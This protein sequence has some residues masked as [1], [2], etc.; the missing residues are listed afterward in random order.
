MATE[1]SQAPAALPQLQSVQKAMAF[2]TVGAAV[3]HVGAFY[4]KV[5]GAHSLLEWALSTAEAGV[6]LAASTAAPYVSAPLAVGDAKVAAA[7][8][9]LERRV[10]LVNEQPKVIVETTKQAVLSRISPHVNKVRLLFIG[11]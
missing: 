11:C 1:V 8:D 5:K 2:P 7:I 9:Q 10:P 6:V 3:E 4:S